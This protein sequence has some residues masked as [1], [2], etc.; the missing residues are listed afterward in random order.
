MFFSE[1]PPPVPAYLPPCFATPASPLGFLETGGAPTPLDIRSG[2]TATRNEII[3]FCRDSLAAYK[4]PRQVQFVD[5][6]PATSSGKIMRRR[7]RTL[8]EV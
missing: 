4:V 5:S 1:T 7:L 2:A 6:V 8:D 3:D